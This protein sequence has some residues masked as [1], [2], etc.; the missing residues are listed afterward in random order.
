[1]WRFRSIVA[2]GV[3]AGTLIFGAVVVYAGWQWNALLDV[4]GVDVRTAWTVVD[5][6]EGDT[7]YHTNIKF[8]HPNEA[9]VEVE[10][11][12]GAE[13][14]ILKPSKKLECGPD[15]IE[16]R[17][18]YKVTALEGAAGSEV[19]VTVT[20]DGEVVGQETGKVGKRINVD[21]LIPG[22]CSGD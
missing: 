16:A 3:L 22:N 20:A 4:E 2:L 9:E 8:K 15:G 14:V 18:E 21:V 13:T 1:M 12:A 19:E 10:E 17:V 7:N 5:D 6:P 11:Q